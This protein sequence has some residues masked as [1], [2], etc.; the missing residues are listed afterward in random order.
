MIVRLIA[1]KISK[2]AGQNKTASITTRDELID[3]QSVASTNLYKVVKKTVN[4]KGATGRFQSLIE[5][6]PETPFQSWTK[7][8][9]KKPTD[10][11][12]YK[13][14]IKTTKG[15]RNEIKESIASTGGFLVCIHYEVEKGSK[16]R[17]NILIALISEKEMPVF[18]K[19]LDL[20]ERNTLDLN[21]LKHCVRVR[22]E[23]LKE[24][25]DNVV[26]FL[27]GRGDGDVSKYF[28]RFIGCSQL[29]SSK[30]ASK[31]LKRRL[32]EWAT[33]EN[34]FGE[35][36]TKLFSRVY[37]FWGDQNCQK[38]GMS[39]E[40]LS[41]Y[42]YPDK[43]DEFLSYITDDTNGIAGILPAIKKSDMKIFT[44]FRFS[45]QDLSL[46]FDRNSWGNNIK[47]N[48]AE[49]SVII[50]NPPEELVQKLQDEE[51]E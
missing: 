45:T 49:E 30:D 27:S 1:H 13:Y 33:K 44:Q 24:N 22:G 50:S 2:E 7:K 5:D 43:T 35:D 16:K 31:G 6:E 3:N 21:N 14:S 47:Y 38:D 39:I 9:L 48:A 10:K 12:F 11:K 29:S 20:N 34:I 23:Y 40:N 18:D 37:S 28:K 17:D 51:I 15:L 36:R 26:Q 19:N 25:N 32:S 8:Y 4:N 42:L 41:T 46:Q